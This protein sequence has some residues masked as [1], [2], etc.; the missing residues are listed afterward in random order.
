[1]FWKRSF[2]KHCSDELLVGHMDGELSLRQGAIVR[3]H[4]KRCWECRG[5]LVKFEEQAQA[6]VKALADPHFPETDR[7]AEAR[8]KFAV[9]EQRFERDFDRGPRLSLLSS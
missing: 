1:M 9:W 2:R 5:R 4:L 6:V 8:Y 3:S 7:I